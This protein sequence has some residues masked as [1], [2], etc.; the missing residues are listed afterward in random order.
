[1]VKICMAL[2][3]LSA[4]VSTA[5]VHTTEASAFPTVGRDSAAPEFTLDRLRA[6]QISV[7]RSLISD[8]A[9]LQGE[10][11]ILSGEFDRHAVADVSLVGAGGLIAATSDWVDISWTSVPGA[12]GYIVLKDDQPFAK[13]AELSM[14]DVAASPGDKPRYMVF[15]TGPFE[16]EARTWGLTIT[17]PMASARELEALES[18]AV[19]QAQSL[20]AI[21]TTLVQHQTFIPQAKI[22]APPASC[23]YVGSSYKYGG[24]N[25]GYIASGFPYRTKLSATINW[26]SGGS[27]STSRAIG[28]TKVYSASSGA[29]I[30]SA[31]ASASGLT[32]TRLGA[33]TSTSVDLRFNINAANPYCSLGSISS[34]FTM[35]VT[36]SQQFSIIS[37]SHKQMPNHELYV[38]DGSTWTTV[39]RR[40]YASA[41]CLI[42]G[43]CPNASMAGYYGS[44]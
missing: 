27:V 43:A 8:A 32:V 40:T 14:R 36:R 13:T 10:I 23:T 3:A 35:T 18:D 20:A 41:L 15:S 44:Y 4:V 24:D 28:T 5:G 6:D 33:S 38:S 12:T 19:I 39:Y 26:L 11:A 25:R 31:T 21:N 22:D 16:S 42:N 9:K 2:V 7:E 37:G 29:L 17:V 34:V 30:A 1:M